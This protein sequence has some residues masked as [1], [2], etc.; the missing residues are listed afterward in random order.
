MSEHVQPLQKG[1]LREDVTN[2]LRA[3]IISG[4]LLPGVLYSAPSLAERFGVSATPVREAMLD[5]AREG[6]V[7]TVRNKGYRVTEIGDEQL[8][9]ITE[10]RL[11]V[12]PPLVARAAGRVPEADFPE[13]RRMADAIVRGAERSDLIDYTESDRIFHLRLLEYAGNRRATGLISELRAH[14]R[15]YGLTAIIEDGQL[16]ESA[17]EHHAILDAIEQRDKRLV[18]R[19]MKRHIAQTRGRWAGR[20]PA[21]AQNGE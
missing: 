14:T 20:A 4:E 1:L 11:L 12:E 10:L 7:V 18:T 21:D 13:L 16:V 17:A 8:D 15:L 6:L 3:A 5:L 9:E 19:L 2:A